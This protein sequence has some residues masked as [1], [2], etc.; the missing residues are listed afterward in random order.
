MLNKYMFVRQ[1]CSDK[2]RTL[3][4]RVREV[5]KF[6]WLY[7]LNDINRSTWKLDKYKIL[8]YFVYLIEYFILI[9]MTV[10]KYLLG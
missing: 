10:I 1:L 6:P 7:M 2:I 4:L 9:A 5:L 8:L 3:F